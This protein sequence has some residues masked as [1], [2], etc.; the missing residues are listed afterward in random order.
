MSIRECNCFR[1]VL[2]AVAAA[3]PLLAAVSLFAQ[4]PSVPREAIEWTDVW[5]PHTNEQNLP[6]V[7]LIGDSITRAY[8]SGVEEQLKGKAWV[9]RIATSKAIGDPALL[10]ELAVFLGEAKFDVVHVNIGMHGWGFTEDE[11]R[12]GL[13]ALLRT[14]RDGAPGARVIWAQ[15]T[16]VRADRE[17]GA[18]NARIEERNRLARAFFTGEGVPVDDLHALMKPHADLHSDDVHFSKEGS[19]LLS[20]KVAQAIEPLLPHR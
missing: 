18:T 11:Y 10:A 20:A 8:Y 2:R 5:M 4:Q 6:R 16:P 12:K 17:K 7:L 13:P 1:N 3:F 15:T 14:I 9:A 19:A